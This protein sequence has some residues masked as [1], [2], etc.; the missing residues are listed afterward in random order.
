LGP[1]LLSVLACSA[2]ATGGPRAIQLTP[3]LAAQLGFSVSI[4]EEPE[5]PGVTTAMAEIVAPTS[6]PGPCFPFRSG[7]ALLNSDGEQ[8]MVFVSE[9]HDREVAPKVL[10]AVT[11]PSHRMAIWF[12]Y[13]CPGAVRDDLY[14]R[15][16]LIESLRD[17]QAGQAK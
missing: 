2:L 13:R 1:A 17:W 3:E 10:G 15:R 7:S 9:I 12:D 6:V 5:Q 11:L 16:Y 4:T 8:L 14:G